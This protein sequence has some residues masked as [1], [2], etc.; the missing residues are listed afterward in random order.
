MIPSNMYPETPVRGLRRAFLQA[1]SDLPTARVRR[2]S[3]DRT[4][5]RPRLEGLEDRCLL[6]VIEYPVPTASANLWGITSGPDNNLWFAE[7]SAGKVGVINPTTHA[8]SDFATPTA[9]SG[10][11]GITSGPDGNLWFAEDAS[12]IGMID[13]ATHAITEFTTPTAGSHPTWIT[14]GPDGN[15]WFTEA[16]NASTSPDQIG[17]INPATH[18]IAEFRVPTANSNL[19]GITAGPDGNLWFTEYA[20]N[21]IGM[22]NPTAHAISEYPIPT[23]GAG[24]IGIAAGPD[25]NLWFAE[26]YGYQIGMINPSTHA[27]SEFAVPTS[28]DGPTGITAGPDGNLW[29]TETAGQI[30]TVDP[31]THAIT[32]FPIPY[33]ST[34]PA[35]ITAGPD[36]N[37]W[38]TD[39]GTNAVGAYYLQNLVVTTQPPASVTAGSS[40]SLTVQAQ[41]ISGNLITSFNGT[42]TLALANNPGG[43]TLGGTLTATASG[44]VATFSGL[45]LTKAASG[46]T[47]TAATPGLGPGITSAM[48]VTPAVAT[49]LVITQQPPATVKVNS[50]FTMKASLEDAYGNVVTTASGTVSV[51]FAN[52]PT[53]A[54]LG[55]T[56]S[57]T[58]SQGV[59]SFTNL[60][61]NKTGSGYTLQVTSGSLTPATSNPINVTKSGN[62]PVRLL[63]PAGNPSPDLSLASLVLDSP[64]LWD[65]LG[66]KRRSR[67][68]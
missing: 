44:G 32:E 12:R 18:A 37:L 47:L 38:F 60:T 35:Y 66:F 49:Q 59:A 13:P 28:G 34:R 64:D 7:F 54:T 39:P 9:S 25:G 68:A 23:A 45:T 53:G 65:G 43:A 3:A 4:R 5:T 51:A 6:S 31:T 40:F 46:Y 21:K 19:R 41:D 15:L 2:R 1:A 42:V 55:G 16:D 11:R 14:A 17:V 33:A 50:P 56:K 67:R 8:A 29:F 22:I 30:G 63:P 26:R 58:A 20:G 10:P 61:I 36:G 57:V 62:A 48:T 24:P 27:I 52:N